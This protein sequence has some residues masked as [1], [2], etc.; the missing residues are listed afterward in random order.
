MPSPVK[1]SDTLLALAREEAR[2]SH[3]SATGQVEHWATL[4][5]AIEA[6]VAYR[7]VLALK[8]AGE[9][10]PMPSFVRRED[11]QDVL[12]RLSQETDRTDVKAR[13]RAS[14]GPIYTTDPDH[15]GTIVEI[16]ADGTRVPG[17]LAGRRFVAARD[18]PVV[19]A[20]RK[21]SPRRK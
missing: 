21:S 15:P 12:A 9:V 1:I 19:H 10:L 2:V 4:G 17:R 18:K 3:R 8:R 5:R 16:K 7:D 11:V 20:R 13:I 14:G 6:M